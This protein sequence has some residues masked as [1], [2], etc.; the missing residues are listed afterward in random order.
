MLRSFSSRLRIKASLLR[1]EQGSQQ[2]LLG[3]SFAKRL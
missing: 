3:D 2:G 1:V